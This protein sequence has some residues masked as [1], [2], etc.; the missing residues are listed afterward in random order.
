MAG[1]G[2]RLQKLFQEDYFSSRLKAYLYAGLVTAGP[3]L[4]VILTVAIIRWLSMNVLNAPFEERTLFNLSVSYA[5]IFS[6]VVLGLQQLVVT[7]YLADKFYGKEFDDIFPAFLGMTKVTLAAAFALWLVFTI[8]TPL[9][10]LYSVVLFLLFAAINIIWVLFLFLSAA[11]F[12]QAVAYSFLGGGLLAVGSVFLV[13]R[14]ADTLL[15]VGFTHSFWLLSGFTFGILVTLFGLLFALF[16]TFPSKKTTGQ[17][18][19]FSYFDRYPALF[20]IG[21]LYNT[22][23]WVCNWVIWFG[24]GR[25]IIGSSFMYNSV[26]DTSV[27]WAYLTIIP[28][29]ILFVVS[30]ETRFY[31]RYRVFYGFI[32][33]GGTLSQIASAMQRMTKVL[34][35]EM[36]RLMRSQGLITFLF[37]LFSPLII[38]WMGISGPIESIFRLTAIGAFSNVMVLVIT[39]LLLYFED[40]KGAVWTAALF[41][42]ANLSL[43]LFLLP[44]GMQWY[45]VSFAAGATLTFMFAAGRLIYFLKSA[46]YFSFCPA[47]Y[48]YLARGTHFFTGIGERLN[49]VVRW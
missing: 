14:F 39:L 2:F 6:Q 32:N 37:I 29:L 4:I 5:F 22:G 9:N 10:F 28:A 13:G 31:E 25:E 26:Y 17:F 12:Y 34:R 1:V 36:E 41:F 48:G 7:R 46:D 40:Q 8:A 23:I 44:M 47:E 21:I 20:W 30:V 16:A 42:T 15:T 49:K 19:Y 11:K 3:W 18:S 38:A 43:T 45:G 33:Y 24:E 35:E 27:F